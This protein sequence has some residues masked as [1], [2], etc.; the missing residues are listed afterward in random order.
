MDLAGI[1]LVEKLH[2]YKGIE[3]NSVVFRGWGVEGRVPAAVNVKH[4]LTCRNSQREFVRMN[5]GR[6][7]LA[8]ST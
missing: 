5:G 4:F 8:P 1:D 3:D 7:S 2:H 6:S